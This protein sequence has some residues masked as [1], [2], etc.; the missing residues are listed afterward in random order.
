MT[1]KVAELTVDELRELL[2]STIR[3]LVEEVIEER[4]GMLTDP[5]ADLELRSEVV[6]SLQEYLESD[7]R[8]DDA[9]DV[10]QALGL[11]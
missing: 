8:G 10:F 3:E 6:N 1:D 5:D 7:Q 2:H 4:M 11:E 9:D